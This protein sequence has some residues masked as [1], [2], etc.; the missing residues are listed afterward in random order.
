M[1]RIRH[2]GPG[3]LIKGALDVQLGHEITKLLGA[4]APWIFMLLI[5]PLLS[6]LFYA[7]WHDSGAFIYLLFA[8]VAALLTFWQLKVTHSR[9]WVGKGLIVACINF[10]TLWL[11]AASQFGIWSRP[12]LDVF[13]VGGIVLAIMSNMRNAIRKDDDDGIINWTK[14]DEKAGF[15]GKTKW[16]QLPNIGS[17][18]RGMVRLKDGMTAKQLM[19]QGDTIKALAGL[20]ANGLRFQ[21]DP[22]NSS[23][24]EVRM[25]TEDVLRKDVDWERSVYAGQSIA[26]GPIKIG[27]YEDGTPAFVHLYSEAGAKHLIISGMNGSGKSV[28]ARNILIDVAERC[29]TRIFAVD[30]AKGSQTLGPMEKGLDLFFTQPALGNAFLTRMKNV[31][32]ERA[33]YLGRK[34]LDSWEPGCGLDFLVLIIEEGASFVNDSDDFIRV[35]ETARSAGVAIILSIQRASHT[36]MPTDARAQ[37]AS[38]LC[39]GVEREMDAR[40]VLSDDLIDR[41]ADP[42]VWK[43]N[44]MGYAYL[45][46]FGVEYERHTIP[47]KTMKLTSTLLRGACEDVVDRDVDPFT[48]NAIGDLYDEKYKKAEMNVS[49]EETVEEEVDAQIAVMKKLEFGDGFE[50]EEITE[51]DEKMIYE[52][53]GDGPVL[54]FVNEEK[55]VKVTSKRAREIFTEELE[56]LVQAGKSEFEAK[57][58]YPVMEKTGRSRPWIHTELNRRKKNGSVAHDSESGAYSI[59]AA[60]DNLG[61]LV[62]AE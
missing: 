51:F 48:K 56:V 47:L 21:P 31:I 1:S 6:L 60:D 4:A 53:P 9:S 35:V 59:I 29:D 32:K 50:E 15:D 16:K 25:Q 46:G 13:I 30:V 12:T 33:D 42:S 39:F 61:E 18:I 19:N 23:L 28:G 44:K 54:S 62:E 8:G 58:L 52:G 7:M 17:T 37:F 34:Q 43:A 22:E 45:E 2:R 38:A 3:A 41:G 10:W 55:A 14:I 40:F 49:K 27:I 5:A 36:N 11:A 57:D 24:I 20:P 26:A